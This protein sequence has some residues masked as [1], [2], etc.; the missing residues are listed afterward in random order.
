MT[1]SYKTLEQ[2]CHKYSINPCLISVTRGKVSPVEPFLRRSQIISYDFSC[3][4]IHQYLNGTY[5]TFN[6][7]QSPTKMEKR[8]IKFLKQPFKQTSISSQQYKLM[9]ISALNRL[10]R[11]IRLQKLVQSMFYLHLFTVQL[12]KRQQNSPFCTFSHNLYSTCNH[13]CVIPDLCSLIAKQ[14]HVSTDLGSRLQSVNRIDI[15]SQ[16]WRM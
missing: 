8:L 15:W 16:T 14:T 9:N 13:E 12:D 3:H 2:C 1:F 11:W 10:I 7:L 4:Y 6:L 5:L